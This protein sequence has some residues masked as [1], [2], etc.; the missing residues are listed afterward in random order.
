MALQ[1]EWRLANSL[2]R[3]LFATVLWEIISGWMKWSGGLSRLGLPENERLEFPQ[4]PSIQGLHLSPTS[5]YDS[6][7]LKRLNQRIHKWLE[8]RTSADGILIEHYP[9]S[10]LTHIRPTFAHRCVCKLGKGGLVNGWVTVTF[11][12]CPPHR[13]Q[14]PCIRISFHAPLLT[15]ELK[16]P[17]WI[18]GDLGHQFWVFIPVGLPRA[19]YRIGITFNNDFGHKEARQMFSLFAS[20]WNFTRPAFVFTVSGKFIVQSGNSCF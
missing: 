6:N 12:L 11:H 18:W 4:M 10:I 9:V 19:F 15:L 14:S 1:R 8:P 7:S 20:S 16:A 13:H 17:V 3:A 5:S 2:I